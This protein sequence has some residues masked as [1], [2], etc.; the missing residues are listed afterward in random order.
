MPENV[1]GVRITNRRLYPVTRCFTHM[2]R[3]VKLQN[4]IKE[5]EQTGKAR[6]GGD[7][8]PE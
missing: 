6:E 7:L 8:R 1:Y 2:L 3:G 4:L 5:I